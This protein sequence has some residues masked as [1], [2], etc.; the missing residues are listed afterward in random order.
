MPDHDQHTLDAPSHEEEGLPVAP[1][2]GEGRGVTGRDRLRSALLHPR[3]NQVVV[4]NF[5]G[6]VALYDLDTG[7]L[8]ANLRIAGSAA[9]VRFNLAGDR[10]FVLSD[11]QTAYAFDLNKLAAANAQPAQAAK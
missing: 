2:A 8:K 7:D 1:A 6:E 10:L 9:F 11:A 4:E 3:R 5:P